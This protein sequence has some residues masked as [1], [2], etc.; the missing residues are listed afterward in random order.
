MRPGAAWWLVGMW[1][2]G[3]LVTSILQG[4]FVKKNNHSRHP[5]PW[6][7]RRLMPW[8]DG[9][10]G[11]VAPGVDGAGVT[12]RPLSQPAPPPGAGGTVAALCRQPG[13]QG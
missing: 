5:P 12:Q 3:C 9:L 13:S 8:V 1:E 6:A 2:C 7:G 11:W 4:V 10:L